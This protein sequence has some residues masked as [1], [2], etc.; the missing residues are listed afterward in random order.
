ME[1]LAL[2]SIVSFVFTTILALFFLYK[3]TRGSLRAVILVSLWLLLLALL[4]LQGFFEVESFPPRVLVLIGPPL[5]L[6]IALFV[7][8]NTVLEQLD[9][10]WSLSLHSIRILVELI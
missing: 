4:S 6:I 5:L 2:Y 3:I 9:I 10:Y 1:N 8:R 7:R